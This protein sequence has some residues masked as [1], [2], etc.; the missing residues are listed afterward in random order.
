MS[1]AIDP[2]PLAVRRRRLGRWPSSRLRVVTVVAAC[3]LAV[4][5]GSDDGV[6]PLSEATVGGP[7]VPDA[8]DDP[9]VTDTPA[10][11]PA[12]DPSEEP[13]GIG[14]D[15]SEDPG[16]GGAAAGG[17]GTPADVVPPGL[18]TSVAGLGGGFGGPEPTGPNPAFG[19]CTDPFVDATGL[20]VTRVDCTAVLS[21]EGITTLAV[22]TSTT[23]GSE[24]WWFA[25]SHGSMRACARVAATLQGTLPMTADGFATGLAVALI[26]PDGTAWPYIAIPAEGC[27]QIDIPGPLPEF[28]APMPQADGIFVRVDTDGSREGVCYRPD[29]ASGSWERDD[30]LATSC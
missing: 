10:D 26:A 14:D 3:S 18:D 17:S 7:V 22:A 24:L 13:D 2:T 11:P 6:S 8:P 20:D 5:C 1:D 15:G 30:G 12:V 29:P 19:L 21:V 9:V 25:G 16:A 23:G 28:T 4:A 27:P